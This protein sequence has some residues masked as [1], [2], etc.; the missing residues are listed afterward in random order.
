MRSSGVRSISS[1][2]SA[3]S[4]IESG[5]VS[6]TRTRVIWATTSFRLSMCWMLTVGVDVDAVVQD[7]LHVEV[8]LGMAAAGRVG[9]GELVD[10]HDLRPA[11]E[12]GVDVH[13]LQPSALVL[14]AAARDDLEALEQRLRLLPAMGLDDP[15]DDIVAVLLAGAR[16]LQHFVGLADARGGADKN[17]KLADAAFLSPRRLQQGVG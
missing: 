15:Y 12:D 8:A 14:H 6:R 5:T 2:E 7:L 3:R 17:A 1:T 11:G 9:V 16:V 4:K 10:Q 13:L